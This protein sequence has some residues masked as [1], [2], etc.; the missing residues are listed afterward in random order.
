MLQVALLLFALPPGSATAAQPVSV[1]PSALNPTLPLGALPLTVAVKVTF[2][3]TSAGLAELVS[4]V[5][6]VVVPLLITCDSAA[7]AEPLFAAS[8]L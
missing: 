5:L 4:V 7:L 1:V 6:L 8:P 3:P 2:V